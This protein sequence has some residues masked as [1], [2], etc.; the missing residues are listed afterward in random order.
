MR[1]ASPP[2]I[3]QVCGGLRRT[4]RRLHPRAGREIDVLQ[5]ADLRQRSIQGSQMKLASRCYSLPRLRSLNRL[6]A[7]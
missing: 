4:R 1:V 6:I 7:E 2:R 5:L 3:G